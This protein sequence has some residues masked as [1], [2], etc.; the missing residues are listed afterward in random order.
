MINSSHKFR[1][2]SLVPSQ[3][4]LL[5]D[6]GLE[7]AIVGVTKF[8]VH[9]K[10]IRKSKMVVGGTKT[11]HLDKIKALNPTFILCN[12]EE[13]TKEIVEAC[14]KIT[15]THTSEIYTINDTLELI[16]IYG[17]FFSKEKEAQN[18]I[19]KLNTIIEDFY[20]FIKNKPTLKVVYFIWKNPWMI[21]ANNT[22]INYLLTLSKFE[23][24]YKNLSRYPEITIENLKQSDFIL[25]S[26]EPYPFKENHIT[27]IRQYA[28]NAKIIL[29]D[30]EYFSW[31]G[32]RL[33]KAFGYFKKLRESI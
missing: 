32:S 15:Q 8:C 21:A 19:L 4:E 11:I 10:N 26:S 14:E 6:L 12:K 2:I 17:G 23:N 13:N 25:L 1:I 31:Y 9:P 5:V 33:L 22:F 18:L 20:Q 24:V 3:T 29:V 30:G 27:E 28:K 16:K 7:N